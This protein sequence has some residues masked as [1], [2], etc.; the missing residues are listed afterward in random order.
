[1]RGKEQGFLA[2]AEVREVMGMAPSE[3]GRPPRSFFGR[4]I[5]GFYI[6]RGP[7][8]CMASQTHSRQIPSPEFFFFN[9]KYL[10]II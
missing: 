10:I 3:S 2:R 5:F 6:K 7:D 4:M 9:L 8:A 1:M